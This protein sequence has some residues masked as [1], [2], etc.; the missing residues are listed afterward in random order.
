MTPAQIETAVLKALTDPDNGGAG[1]G[2]NASDRRRAQEIAAR[3]TRDL[4]P[5]RN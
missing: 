4:T 3:I 5:P 1:M 2:H